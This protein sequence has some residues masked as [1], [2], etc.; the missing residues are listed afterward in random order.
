MEIMEPKAGRLLHL[1]IRSK[2][3]ILDKVRIIINRINR[4]K[5][6]KVRQTG[7]KEDAAAA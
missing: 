3:E 4:V 7:H 5:G 1:G 2:A 6:G